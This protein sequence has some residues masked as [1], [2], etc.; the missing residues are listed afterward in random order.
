M[1]FNSAFKGLNR[2]LLR[3]KSSVSAPTPDKEFHK[4][5]FCISRIA[6]CIETVCG[7]ANVRIF[8][9]LCMKNATY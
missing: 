5:P 2:G 7:E 6:L 1:G 8:A 9:N 4:N 3:R